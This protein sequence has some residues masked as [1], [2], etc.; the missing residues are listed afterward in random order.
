MTT[1]PA[2]SMPASLRSFTDAVTDA[3]AREIAEL[4]RTAQAEKDARDT[5]HRERLALLDTRIAA[6]AD[7][8]RQVAERLATL[9]D[10]AD[11][12][13]EVIRSM[14]DEAVSK[15]P[16]PEPGKDGKLPI[17]KAWED[18]V[19]YEGDVVTHEG[20]TFQANKDTGRAP[21]HDDWNCIARG[22]VDG[23]PGRSFRIRGTFDP[24]AFAN[25]QPAYEALDVVALNGAAFVARRDEPGPCPGEGWQMI[26]AQG[27]PGRP[28]PR[29]EKLKGDRGKDGEP[30][31]D[32]SITDEALL[33]LTNGDGTQ[34]TC[35]LYPLLS[36][37]KQ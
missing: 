27:K 16:P 3:I 20:S 31:V 4:R 18:R 1:T 15:L 12:D 14:V 17:V 22:G 37:L 11:A 34:I 23:K 19:H 33:I 24:E 5:E 6:V 7:L 25:G 21:P 28:G 30:V 29:G 35:D 9:K 26:S 36:R 10:G 8:E 2:N 13:P 32:M